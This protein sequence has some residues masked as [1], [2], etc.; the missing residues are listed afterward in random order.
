MDTWKCVA[1]LRLRSWVRPASEESCL[2]IHGLFVCRVGERGDN[3]VLLS[4]CAS[5]WI[6]K[7]GSGQWLQHA[8][9]KSYKP[10][11][12]ARHLPNPHQSKVIRHQEPNG[13]G[14]LVHHP[15]M[16]GPRPSTSDTLANITV[17][18]SL[19][20]EIPISEEGHIFAQVTTSV[21]ILSFYT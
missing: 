10:D 6:E 8:V 20:S 19:P 17:T 3:V 2:C 15:G 12:S 11:A 14:K 5:N 9:S 21:K 4:S 16:Q 1:G 13:S 7:P 18:I